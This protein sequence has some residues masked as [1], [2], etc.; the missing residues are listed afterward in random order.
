MTMQGLRHTSVALLL[1]GA[2]ATL[3]VLTASADQAGLDLSVHGI[4]AD[5]YPLVTLEIGLPAEM[6][7]REGLAHPE[8]EVTE[9]GE[10]V[11]LARSSR[12]DPEASDVNIVLVMD[13]SRSMK[14]RPLEDAQQA[15]RTFCADMG[16]RAPVALVAF[17]S[18]PEVVV[19][20]TRDRDSLLRGVE[21]LTA[22][23]GTAVYDA[24]VTSARILSVTREGRRV[25]VLLSDGGDTSSVRNLDM[26][27]RALQDA[28]AV[29]LSVALRSP[30]LNE[31]ALGT[32]ASRTRGRSVSFADSGGLSDYYAG[33]AREFSSVYSV[34]YRSSEPHT[35]DI[36]VD[37]R[38]E[39]GGR[40]ATAATVFPNPAYLQAVE[41]AGTG[42]SVP[43]AAPAYL[44][45]SVSLAFGSVVILA[46]AGLLSLLG[47][48]G[49]LDQLRYYDQLHGETG[50]PR[51]PERDLCARVVEAVGAVAGRRGFT[52]PIAQK[53]ERAGVSLRPAEYITAH[54]TT[55]VLLGWVVQMLSG[56]LTLSLVTIVLASVG[57]LALLD[58][59][60]RRRTAAFDAQLP[61][62]LN[63][64][65]GGLRT[66][67][68]L[69]QA[70]ELVVNE[71]RPPASV[72]FKRVQIETRLGVPVEQSL[73]GVADRLGSRQF[74]WVVVAVAIQREVGGNLAEVLDN[75]AR[76]VR[77]REALERQVEALT[78]EGK[79]S[80]I[81]LTVLPFAVAGGLWLMSPTY[82]MTAIGSP[83]GAAMFTSAGLLLFVGVMWLRRVSR[84]EY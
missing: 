1:V 28:N 62:V 52:Q 23:G 40:H 72:E 16:G 68:G 65:A 11:W 60:G 2:L 42:L 29:V 24:L 34:T 31:S 30:D 10:A 75:V 55:V 73:Q 83:L 70:L 58:G 46:F 61:D 38:A 66:G 59:K 74:A 64:V 17:S 6:L 37:I 19:P 56:D 54:I 4:D 44:V 5:S 21:S 51:D 39:A 12:L 20:F 63:L 18:E 80:A 43:A 35:K 7:D 69:Q 79:L 77:D 9:N 57:P 22:H 76:S 27:V 33:L 81:I 47:R 15:A 14:G 45:G 41:W 13:T 50:A 25:V 67:W 49:R 32:L 82:M 71:G 78:A 36:E 3:P 26:T 48:R 53:L 8:F 84:I